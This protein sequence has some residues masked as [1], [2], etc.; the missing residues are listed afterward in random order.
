MLNDHVISNEAFD[1]IQAALALHQ[2]W[3]AYNTVNYFLDRGDVHLFESRND[4]VEFADNNF[5]D[6]DNYMVVQVHSIADVMRNI[7]YG[8][9]LDNLISDPDANGLYNTDGNAFTDALIDH[10]EQQQIIHSNKSNVMNENNFK[11]LDDQIFYTNL[12][13]ALYY[14]KVKLKTKKSYI[15]YTY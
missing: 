15:I 6:R 3:L 4:A 12:L 14:I 5:S 13:G 10:I 1:D 8:E 7:P 11:Y 9:Q 2:H